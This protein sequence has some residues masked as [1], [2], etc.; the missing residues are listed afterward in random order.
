MVNGFA[1]PAITAA[2]RT[3]G[4]SPVWSAWAR[5]MSTG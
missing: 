2:N 4:S 5:V 3:A 1:P